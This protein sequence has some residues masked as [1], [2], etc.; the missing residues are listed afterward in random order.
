MANFE[1]PFTSSGTPTSFA[2]G[3]SGITGVDEAGTITPKVVKLGAN[4]HLLLTAAKTDAEL[5][6]LAEAFIQRYGGGHD[7]PGG[8]STQATLQVAP[9][10]TN[11]GAAD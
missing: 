2:V 4:V 9:A 3:D 8:A 7:G 1:Y 6:T 11:V 5:R 10:L